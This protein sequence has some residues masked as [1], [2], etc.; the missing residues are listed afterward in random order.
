MFSI[1][2]VKGHMTSTTRN[3][4]AMRPAVSSSRMGATGGAVGAQLA[5]ARVYVTLNVT[6]ERKR[7][8]VF[9]PKPLF[10]LV[11]SPDFEPWPAGFPSGV[12]GAG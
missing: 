9:L 6:L 7:A 2:N 8:Q 1:K 4:A 12:A 3:R 11:S 10:D 5:T